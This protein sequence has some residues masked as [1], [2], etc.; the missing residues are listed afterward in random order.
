MR[1]GQ[2]EIAL[3]MGDATLPETQ[4]GKHTY[5]QAESGGEYVV[6]VQVYRNDQG[7]FP[8]HHM[9]IGVYVDGQDVQYWKRLDTTATSTDSISCLFHGFKR[10]NDDLRAFVFEPPMESDIADHSQLESAMGTIR[11]EI[12][13]AIPAEGVFHNISRKYEVP[14]KATVPLDRKFHS[15][16]S[17]TTVGGRNI[18]TAETFAPVKRWINKDP[19]HPMAVLVLRYHTAGVIASLQ[20]MGAA[21]PAQTQRAEDAA[22]DHK[23]DR[24]NADSGSVN[25]RPCLLPPL[26]RGGEGG[27][28]GSASAAVDLTGDSDDDTQRG[29]GG[30][31]IPVAPI[32][33][34]GSGGGLCDEGEDGEVEVV[35]VVKR[36]VEVDITHLGSDDDS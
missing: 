7:T 13:E 23:R 22:S 9:R 18:S 36:R 31:T 21:P 16:P 8:A 14:S 2:F 20:A 29:E 19:Q 25:K 26:Q 1:V 3:K 6:R 24:Q 10:G 12:F 35:E 28:G 11:V 17:I 34:E 33:R 15:A 27:E 32:L 4:I 5:A 30:A